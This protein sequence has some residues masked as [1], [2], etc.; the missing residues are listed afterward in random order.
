[1]ETVPNGA[2]LTA[3][4]ARDQR[5]SKEATEVG[6]ASRGGLDQRDHLVDRRQ[7]ELVPTD[8]RRCRPGRW[9]D[10]AP[11]PLD[12]LVEETSKHGVDVMDGLRAHWAP[13]LPSRSRE[14]GVELVELRGS[15][16]PDLARSERR[17]DVSIKERR[18]AAARGGGEAI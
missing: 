18:V 10:S 17:E 4:S 3:T 12:R 15:D 5:K 9:I 2:Q 13:A 1:M 16:C 6:V 7:L 8:S 14:P 11:S